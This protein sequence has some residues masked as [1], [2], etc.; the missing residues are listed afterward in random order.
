M[1]FSNRHPATNN[2]VE[3]EACILDLETALATRFFICGKTLSRRS[4]NGMLLLCYDQASTNQVVREVHA[5][6]CGPHMG[7]H[8]LTRKIMRTSYFWLTMK[9]DYCQFVQKCPE[10]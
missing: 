7:E 4:I 8:M 5:G 10:C 6:V 2:I 3:Y 1:A 9:T